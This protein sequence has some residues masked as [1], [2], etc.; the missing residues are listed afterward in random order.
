MKIKKSASKR[1][2]RIMAK[3]NGISWRG[4]AMA[5]IIAKYHQ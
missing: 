1:K 3:S 5:A 4:A 2:Q